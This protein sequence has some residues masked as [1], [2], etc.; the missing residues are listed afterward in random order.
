MD[1]QEKAQLQLDRA[2]AKFRMGESYRIILNLKDML[3]SYQECWQ[4]WDRKFKHAD[5]LLA[6]EEKLTKVKTG[7]SGIEKKLG[8]TSDIQLLMNL[9]SDQVR[10]LAE[11]LKDEM[12]KGGMK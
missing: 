2:N 5:R 7:E 11:V 4:K 9:S 1:N 8:K 6:E 10:R 3:K 12:E